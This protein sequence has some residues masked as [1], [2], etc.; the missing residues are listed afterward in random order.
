[1]LFRIP[2]S[3]EVLRSLKGEIFTLD[4]ERRDSRPEEGVS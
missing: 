1:M 4:A 3:Q 2:I